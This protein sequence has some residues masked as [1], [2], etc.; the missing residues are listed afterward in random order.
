M[1]FINRGGLLTEA[2]GQEFVGFRGIPRIPSLE[3]L[4]IPTIFLFFFDIRNFD[5]QI[6][7]FLRFLEVLEGL[8]SC[9]RLVGSIST[10]FHVQEVSRIFVE[11]SRKFID[12]SKNFLRI[13]K[14][15]L[16]ISRKFQDISKKILGMSMNNSKHVSEMC[17]TYV[18]NVSEIRPW[19][20]QGRFFLF[21]PSW[22]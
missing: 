18:G 7:V 21:F 5:L 17:R 1:K 12:I 22:L 10:Y 3:I 20:S 15:F 9:G 13:S 16:D 19:N 8:G 14:M 6:L 11:M 2:R 4:G